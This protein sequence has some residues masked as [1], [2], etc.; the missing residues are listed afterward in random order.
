MTA[1][2]AAWTAT[3]ITILGLTA[4]GC[5]TDSTADT[6][7]DT[8]APLVDSQPSDVASTPPDAAPSDAAPP[9]AT[10]NDAAEDLAPSPDT[11]P[12]AAASAPT[13]VE[14]VPIPAGRFEMGCSPGDSLCFD[15]ERPRHAVDVPAFE[16]ASTE[17]TQAQFEAVMGFN[18]SGVSICARCPADTVMWHEAVEFCEAVG[19]RLPSESEWEHAAR[20]GTTGAHFC[21][22]DARVD[23]IAWFQPNADNQTHPVGRKT[24]N[25]FAL[26]DTSGNVWEWVQDCWHDD[27][28]DGPPNDGSAWISGADCSFRVL[29]GGSWGLELRGVRVSN[30][31]ADYV[32]SYLLPP[33]GFRCARDIGEH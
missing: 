20:A 5:E 10:P 18:P 12:D 3:S 33:P 6:P 11:E 9:D 13:E 31:D 22:D 15:A 21:G 29:R 28:S 7:A 32:D 19:G 27:Y 25:R 23:E 16:M 24:P 1:N 8:G 17:T 26:Y 4:S 14:W 2:A 30:R